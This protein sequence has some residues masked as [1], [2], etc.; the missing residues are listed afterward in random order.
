MD[1][2]V[3]LDINLEPKLYSRIMK[4]TEDFNWSLNDVSNHEDYDQLSYI[5]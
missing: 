3:K 1:D 2:F 5:L 4:L